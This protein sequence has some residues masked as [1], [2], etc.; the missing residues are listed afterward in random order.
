MLRPVRA[1][2]QERAV[3]ASERRKGGESVGGCKAWLNTR[4]AKQ[5]L[6]TAQCYGLH[7]AAA[8]G[9]RSGGPRV[10]ESQA[11]HARSFSGFYGNYVTETTPEVRTGGRRH[12]YSNVGDAIH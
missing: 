12:T 6:H 7:V 3:G 10:A 8:R 2:E 4:V 5:T 1:S 9:S 11:A